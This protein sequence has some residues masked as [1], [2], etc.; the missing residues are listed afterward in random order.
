M[1]AVARRTVTKAAARKPGRAKVEAWR[2]QLEAARR[3]L[4]LSRDDLARV[5]GVSASTVRGYE[6]G[7]RHPRQDSLEAILG[8][9]HL[10]LTMANPIREAA[11][12]APVRSLWD[13]RPDYYFSVE[14]LQEYVERMPWPLFVVNDSMEVCAANRVAGAL[15]GL[16][17]QTERAR[18]TK[19]AM[20]LLAVA[21][22]HDFPAAVENWDEILE[23]LCSVYKGLSVVREGNSGEIG[24]PTPYLA[25]VVGH[26]TDTDPRFLERLI[27]AWEHSVPSPAKVR[28]TYR[29]IWKHALGR[30][31]FFCLMSTANEREGL[32][33]NEW[34]PVNTET[35]ESLHRLLRSIGEDPEKYVA[36]L[37]RPRRILKP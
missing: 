31:S 34:I 14:E 17:F 4:G 7:R 26:F 8:A 1:S 28:Q 6:D 11:G 30:M 29:V 35:W 37:T 10:D 9:L 16:D 15:W 18:R 20:N 12:F 36:W 5:A 19:F 3:L 23:L 33:F 27:T 32:A 24:D 13:D 25:Q 2:M 22:E 21:S